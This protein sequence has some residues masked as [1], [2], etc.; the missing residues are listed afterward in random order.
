[1]RIGKLVMMSDE[2][3][4]DIWVESKLRSIKKH[5]EFRAVVSYWDDLPCSIPCPGTIWQMSGD[6]EWGRLPTCTYWLEARHEMSIPW[7]TGQPP[8]QRIFWSPSLNS[9]NLG[10][11]HFEGNRVWD[12]AH[13]TSS[14]HLHWFF[15]VKPT[16]FTELLQWVWF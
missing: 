6:V 16:V 1:M 7:C 14:F 13:F 10:L 9:E 12:T 3:Y 11:G 15:F 5:T 8:K 2:S 4:V